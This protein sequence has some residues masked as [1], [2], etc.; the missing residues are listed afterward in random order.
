[1]PV[2][3]LPL[4]NFLRFPRGG[5]YSHGPA[6]LILPEQA[7]GNLATK[8]QTARLA[9][10]RDKSPLVARDPAIGA[11]AESIAPMPFDIR[12]LAL[13]ISAGTNKSHR[14]RLY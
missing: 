5:I 12:S 7:S 11:F 8:S 9:M 3:N 2:A 13:K 14:S 4:R 1:M 6:A 10:N